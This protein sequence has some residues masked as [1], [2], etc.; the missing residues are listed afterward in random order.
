MSKEKDAL[1][2]MNKVFDDKKGKEE[3]KYVEV[4]ENPQGPRDFKYSRKLTLSNYDPRRKFETE[5]FG[6]THD[7]FEQAR[8]LVETAVKNRIGELRGVEALPIKQ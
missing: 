7:S 1:T 2:S 4:T 3:P 8:E 5:D 6:V